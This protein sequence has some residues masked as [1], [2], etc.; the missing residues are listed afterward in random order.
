MEYN[1]LEEKWSRIIINQEQNYTS[2]NLSDDLKVRLLIGFNKNSKRCLI[3]SLLSNQKFDFTNDIRE[4]ISF[5]YF[6][7]SGH[8][9]VTLNDD[10]FQEQFNAFIYSTYR[11]LIAVEL[12][13]NAAFIFVD[14]YHKWREFFSNRNNNLLSDEEVLG[15]FGELVYLRKL[16]L[17]TSAQ[18][19]NEKL[20]GWVGPYGKGHD[21]EFSDFDVEIKTKDHLKSFINI[22]SEYQLEKNSDKDVILHIISVETDRQNGQTLSDL[23]KEINDCLVMKFADI[24]IFLKT[25]RKAGLIWDDLK[26]YDH[27]K[28]TVLSQNSYDCSTDNFPKLTKS[29]IPS[30]ISNVKYFLSVK[31]LEVFIINTP[32]NRNGNK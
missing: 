19:V 20:E 1:S 31:D 30:G 9:I 24:S 25:L 5:E 2:I 6:D 16:L 27:K 7:D 14:N 15:L 26:K 4:Y 8:L 22:S 13:K 21:F 18:L 32:I 23:I 11:N 29:N 3:L 17:E 28:F 10:R 12:I